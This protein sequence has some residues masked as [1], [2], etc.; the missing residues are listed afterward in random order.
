MPLSSLQVFSEYVQTAMGELIAQEIDKFNAASRGTI[1]L[2]PANREGDFSDETFWK[3]ISGLVRRRNAYGSGAIAAVDLEQ[4]SDAS[5]KIAAGSFPV[6]L[7]PGQFKWI[8]K[9]PKEAAV[10]VARQLSEGKL[11]D[12]LNTA[13]AAKVAFLR[14]QAA[15]RHTATTAGIDLR[16]MNRG[17]QKF[18][19]RSNALQAWV[20]HS[21]PMFDVYDAALANATDLFEFG[22]V[23]VKT[24]GYGRVFIISD[25][26]SLVDVDGVSAGVDRYNSL[27]LAA[28]AV[29]VEENDEFTDVMEEKTGDENIQRVYQAEWT[30]NLG[31]KGASWDKTDGGKSPT[32]A[33]L[34]TGANWEKTAT[35]H[36]DLGGV[37]V[38]TR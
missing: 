3:R 28:G 23:N 36:K 35:S 12:M 13:V 22:T 2:R 9:N 19:D 21:T 32:D 1:V 38:E 8:N 37:L 25:S 7:P 10:E 20:M 6:N 24:D 34:T 31:L 17:I 33:A 26:P 5:V 14:T 16:V 27:A 11:A 4:L 30:Y 29:M 18:G 15:N